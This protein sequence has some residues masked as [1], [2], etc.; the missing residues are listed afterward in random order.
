MFAK[1]KRPHE[2]AESSGANPVPIRALPSISIRRPPQSRR[3]LTTKP[4]PLPTRETA[5][6]P[7]LDRM[8]WKEVMKGV[9]PWGARRGL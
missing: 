6:D 8:A 9:R 5:L 1:L 4:R 3:W 2:A 7:P